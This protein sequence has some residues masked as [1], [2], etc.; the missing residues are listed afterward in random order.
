MPRRYRH[1][2]LGEFHKV[3][4]S[5]GNLGPTL[6]PDAAFAGLLRF[7]NDSDDQAEGGKVVQILE[8]MLELEAIEPPAWSERISGPLTVTRK[9]Q[10]FP[11]P[12][13]KKLAPEKYSKQLDID[14]RRFRINRELGGYR[15]LP[16]VI[17]PVKIAPWTSKHWTVGWQIQSRTP[18]RRKTQS[19]GEFLLGEGEALQMILDLAKAGLLNRLRRCSRCHKW[20]YAKFRHQSFCSTICQQKHYAKSEEWRAKRREYMRRYRQSNY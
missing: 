18:E 5:K 4:T 9:G 3:D 14:E 19:P 16:F 8:Q 7:L 13:L 10:V 12:I 20:L 1:P 17:P 6:L 11:N 15:F 2:D